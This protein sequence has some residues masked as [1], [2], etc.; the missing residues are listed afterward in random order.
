MLILGSELASFLITFKDSLYLV[1]S[2]WVISLWDH[3][4]LFQ[5]GRPAL[6]SLCPEVASLTFA[7]GAF[8]IYYYAQQIVDVQKVLTECEWK[9]SWLYFAHKC[10]LFNFQVYLA[11]KLNTFMWLSITYL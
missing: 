11:A 3:T 2:H 9:C 8:L 4:L 7:L 1:I 5:V 10:Y 6:F